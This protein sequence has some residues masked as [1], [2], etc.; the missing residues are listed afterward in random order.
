MKMLK[1]QNITMEIT[2]TKASESL[3][4]MNIEV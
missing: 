3:E 1:Q 2:T 4:L